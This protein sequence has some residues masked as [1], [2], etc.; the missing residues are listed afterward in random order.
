M[1]AFGNGRLENKEPLRSFSQSISPADWALC[2]TKRDVHPQFAFL[3]SLQGP[4]SRE[5]ADDI[6]RSKLRVAPRLNP[7]AKPENVQ[8]YP[9]PKFSFAYSL[10]GSGIFFDCR[11]DALPTHRRS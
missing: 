4:F 8:A 9:A 5:A 6:E 3:A 1:P 7:Q 10:C 11:S 2:S